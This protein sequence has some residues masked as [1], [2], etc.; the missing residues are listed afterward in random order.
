MLFL[1]QQHALQA[2]NNAVS[3]SHSVL[4]ANS[5]SILIANSHSALIANSHSAL[6]ANSK[7]FA[8]TLSTTL[9]VRKVLGSIPRPSELSKFPNTTKVTLS[10]PTSIT[11]SRCYYHANTKPDQSDCVITRVRFVDD[12]ANSD[13][14][15]A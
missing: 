8:E 9:T 3:K 2:I 6:I 10:S 1:D 4:T 11:Q 12:S 15:N 14:P 5:H 13:S 7:N